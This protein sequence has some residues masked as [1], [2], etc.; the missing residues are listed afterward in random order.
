MSKSKLHGFLEGLNIASNQPTFGGQI[1]PDLGSF[2]IP[3]A[4][5]R[6]KLNNG[7][8]W[9]HPAMDL[10]RL[11]TKFPHYSFDKGVPLTYPK[12][13]MEELR[14]QASTALNL[15][16]AKL[17][18]YP[19]DMRI[20]AKVDRDQGEEYR[21]TEQ[22]HPAVEPPGFLKEAEE[23]M[24]MKP[25]YT[26][27]QF[28]RLIQLGFTEEMIAKAVEEELNE[29]IKNVLKNPS[30]YTRELDAAAS[31]DKI[32]ETWKIRRDTARTGMGVSEGTATANPNNYRAAGT[33]SENILPMRASTGIARMRMEM[34]ERG[35]P[36]SSMEKESPASAQLK[37]ALAKFAS[38][39]IADPVYKIGGIEYGREREISK[40]EESL[41]S[42]SS[43]MS[44]AS[45]M[46]RSRGRPVGTGRPLSE[47]GKE[48]QKEGRERAKMGKE[49]KSA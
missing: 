23:A 3:T 2:N 48:R 24:R 37:G 27:E 6:H 20:K 5:V 18:M 30:A 15:T 33:Y 10:P 36:Y 12:D 7:Q 32:Y 38:K 19:E 45:P 8:E 22:H 44:N 42:M 43:S 40:A 16:P 35:V 46:F 14:G 28:D 41:L 21:Q 26:P 34:A 47:A 25:K 17:P 4:L 31:L 1:I 11:E 9:N 39:P 13:L 49:D 29:D